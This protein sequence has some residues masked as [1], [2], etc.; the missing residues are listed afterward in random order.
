MFITGLMNGSGLGTG[1]TAGTA[2]EE[3]KV[4]FTAGSA[5]PPLNTEVSPRSWGCSEKMDQ[6]EAWGFSGAI[7]L[8]IADTAGTLAVMPSGSSFAIME[9]MSLMALCCIVCRFHDFVA[10]NGVLE[11][12]DFQ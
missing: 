2:A 3:P 7:R 8:N 1:F 10:V 5:V 6:A 12:L 4:N 9:A 11:Q